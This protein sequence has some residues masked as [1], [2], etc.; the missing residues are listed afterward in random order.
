MKYNF[1]RGDSTLKTEDIP[2]EQKLAMFMEYYAASFHNLIAALDEAHISHYSPGCGMQRVT[3]DIFPASAYV[4]EFVAMLS[5]ERAHR[6]KPIGGF[7]DASKTGEYNPAND[8]IQ[9]MRRWLGF[10]EQ[11]MRVEG[12][13][14]RGTAA[15]RVKIILDDLIERLAGGSQ[16]ADP[17]K[18]NTAK[19]A[20]FSKLMREIGLSLESGR[21]HAEAHTQAQK[22]RA[23]DINYAKALTRAKS[24]IGTS[25]NTF[26]TALLPP[27][28]FA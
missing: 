2:V 24:G 15:A 25:E 27:K 22:A 14:D 17:R 28:K 8:F 11:V 12:D 3:F 5:L 1:E 4:K 19:P 9:Y 13:S 21:K 23:T 20:E 16:N 26:A 7:R 18:S 10:S 6:P